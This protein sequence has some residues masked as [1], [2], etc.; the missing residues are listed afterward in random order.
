MTRQLCKHSK[1]FGR[2]LRLW[3]ISTLRANYFQIKF[4]NE[5][6]RKD[7]LAKG[8]W[9]FKDKWLAIVAFNPSY[10][11]EDYTF[12]T[13][14]IL[15][16]IH[17]VPSILMEDDNFAHQIGESLGAMIGKVVKVDTRQ[18]DLNMVDYL[19]IGIILD[20]TKLVRRCVA[21]GGTGTSPNFFPLQY[22]RLSTIC[23]GCGLVRHSLE[24]CLTFKQTPT[25][26]LQ[27]GDWIRYVPPRKEEENPRTK[28][29]A[30]AESTN[31]PTKPV[32]IIT[33]APLTPVMLDITAPTMV[34][35]TIMSNSTMTTFYSMSETMD[36]TYFILVIISN[37]PFK[38]DSLSIPMFNFNFSM[39]KCT[40]IELSKNPETARLVASLA[41]AADPH[42]ATGDIM[43]SP[44]VGNLMHVTNAPIV[45]ADAPLNTHIIDA[46]KGKHSPIM[47][48][49]VPA[50]TVDLS[51]ASIEFGVDMAPL[52]SPTYLF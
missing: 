5:E 32:D 20:V 44:T 6:T 29:I 37:I 50:H 9:T 8:P 45:T 39:A 19:R 27:Y 23:H 11:L 24:F 18:I 14:N 51:P 47:I 25:S 38:F 31:A 15:V 35:E 30:D 10:N 3:N 21:I 42:H 52:G 22:E 16:R 4:P 1:E 26:K 48:S 41:A 2:K 43:M 36:N 12:T 46:T 28:G 49:H 33:I 17:S 13:M 7:I 40:P 34:K